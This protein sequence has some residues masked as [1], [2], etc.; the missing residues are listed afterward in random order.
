MAP[1]RSAAGPIGAPSPKS[2]DKLHT[3]RRAPGHLT[4]E[5]LAS[6]GS[7]DSSSLAQG[8]SPAATGVR[9]YAGV[10]LGASDQ[11]TRSRLALPTIPDTVDRAEYDSAMAEV[12]RLK[13]A[14][15]RLQSEHGL[16]STV[17]AEESFAATAAARSVELRAQSQVAD[18][19]ARA[20]E[21]VDSLR[22]AFLAEKEQGRLQ[23]AQAEMRVEQVVSAAGADLAA[24][25][26]CLR[27]DAESVAQAAAASKSA[28][29]TVLD[30]NPI[31]QIQQ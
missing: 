30:I 18:A 22:F 26:A 28:D 29:A 8:P 12:G 25:R 9:P 10:P 2:E 16:A 6:G 15:L 21:T 24:E 13:G 19:V 1:G 23:L 5:D 31:H 17:A 20:Q 4:F 7:T 11:G 27:A 14:T 3:P